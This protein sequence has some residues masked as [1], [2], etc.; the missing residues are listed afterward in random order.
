MHRWHSTLAKQAG[1]KKLRSA[2]ERVYIPTS[3]HPENGFTTAFGEMG[4]C[5]AAR[6]ATALDVAYALTHCSTFKEGIIHPCNAK[7]ADE[8]AS[9]I[10]L[11]CAPSDAAVLHGNEAQ[12]ST[13]TSQRDPV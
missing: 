4:A 10:R 3:Y 9:E 6:A 7:I 8:F 1:V 11:C 12:S 2:S 5:L 13:L